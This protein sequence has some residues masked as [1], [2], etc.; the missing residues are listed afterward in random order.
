MAVI[1]ARADFRSQARTSQFDPLPVLRLAVRR[2]ARQSSGIGGGWVQVGFRRYGG[3]VHPQSDA[4]SPHG[5]SASAYSFAS[6]DN[7]TRRALYR[8]RA[9]VAAIGVDRRPQ[10]T[11]GNSLGQATPPIRTNTPRNCSRSRRT[12][13]LLLAACPSFATSVTVPIV[14]AIVPDPVGSGFVSLSPPG[15]NATGL[16]QF[17]YPE[18]EIAG[19]A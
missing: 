13:S 9:A 1:E 2:C 7:W 6:A 3:C 17:E 10:Y 8:F 18:R 19:T 5:S 12:L 14:F 15:G 4:Q 16:M 11:A